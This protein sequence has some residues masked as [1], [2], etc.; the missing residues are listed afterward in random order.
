ML[1]TLSRSAL[2]WV[3]VGMV[4]GPSGGQAQEPPDLWRAQVDLGFQGSWGST[5]FSILTLGGS[6]TRLEEERFELVFSGRLRYGTSDGDV[7]AKGL[8]PTIRP[9]AFRR[10]FV[11][12]SDVE[13]L[14]EQ[15]TEQAEGG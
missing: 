7:I 5:S 9:P 11:R 2:V 8:I 15:W 1:Q 10:V 4:F 12:R 14:L 13:T 6:L 3:G